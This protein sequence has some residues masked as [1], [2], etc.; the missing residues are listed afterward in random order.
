M[1]W[2]G[3]DADTGD[4]C[5]RGEC[6]ASEA[7]GDD[8]IEVVGLANLACCVGGQGEGELLLRDA[9]AIVADADELDAAFVEIDFDAGCSGVKAV[10]DEFLDD[11]GGAFDDLAGGDLIDQQRRERADGVGVV[12][13]RLGGHGSIVRRRLLMHRLETG[14][15][16]RLMHRLETGTT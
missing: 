16:G 3:D 2:F 15:T 8:A 4:G 7:H 12:N 5:D 1:A 11:A 13:G 10:F 9:S 6:F 14:T